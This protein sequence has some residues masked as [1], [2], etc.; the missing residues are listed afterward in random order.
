MRFRLFAALALGLLLAAVSPLA[1]AAGPCGPVQ[2]EGAGYTVC[3]FDLRKTDLRIF[4]RDRSGKPYLGFSTLASSLAAD[5]LS[6]DFAMNGGMF[7]DDYSP[8]GLFIEKG[9]ELKPANTRKGPGNF[10]LKPNGVFYID[11]SRAGVM[12]TEAFL[13]KRPKA[14]FATQSGPMLVTNRRIHPRF[15]A[16][17]DSLK[18]RNGVGVSDAR[19]VYFAISETGVNF[20][21]FARLFRDKLGCPNAL[22]LDGS[23]SGLYAPALKRDDS[24]HLFGPIIGAVRR[25]S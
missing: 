4:W 1:R 8:V 25:K 7:H 12:E 6:L 9:D 11:G 19:H 3:S 16:T 10:H 23:V 5:G 15:V 18:I 22:F 24:W 20:Y 14:E 13:S 21:S 17:S 2:F